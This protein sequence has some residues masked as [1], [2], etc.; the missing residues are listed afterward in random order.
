MALRIAEDA[1]DRTTASALMVRGTSMRVRSVFAAVG[2]VVHTGLANSWSIAAWITG[3]SGVIVGA[4]R[5][6][7]VPSRATRNFS[8]FH[9][10]SGS[11]VVA[12][13]WPFSVS[14]NASS[15]P[16]SRSAAGH[17]YFWRSGP[18]S[19]LRHPKTCPLRSELHS[20]FRLK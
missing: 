12:M 18:L 7:T 6:T 13:L 5:R 2:L 16:T 20:M 15:R 8:K 9:S 11:S 19:F 3:S 4:K 1:E 14:R 10:T 17:G